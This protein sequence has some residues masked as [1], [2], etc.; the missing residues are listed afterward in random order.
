MYSNVDT[1]IK[2]ERVQYLLSDMLSSCVQ[3]CPLNSTLFNFSYSV[4]HIYYLLIHK[5]K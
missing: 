3:S 1:E 5:L 4:V 2:I